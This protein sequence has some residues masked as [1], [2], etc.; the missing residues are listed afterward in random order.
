MEKFAKTQAELTFKF[1]TSDLTPVQQRLLKHIHTLTVHLLKTDDESE[2]F[3]ASAEILKQVVSMIKHSDFPT[4]SKNRKIPY[5]EQSIEL[6][7]EQIFE[8]VEQKKHI[9]YDN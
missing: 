1:E 8:T 9:N 5:A 7:L 6:A 4:Q 3:E 2:Y